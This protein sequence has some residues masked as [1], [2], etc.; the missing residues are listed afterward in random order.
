MMANQGDVE[1]PYKCYEFIKNCLNSTLSDD[2][3][4]LELSQFFDK[5]EDELN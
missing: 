4:R 5:L 3:L 1:D 2:E